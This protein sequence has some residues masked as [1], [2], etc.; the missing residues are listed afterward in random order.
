MIWREC[1]AH[2]EERKYRRYKKNKWGLKLAGEEGLSDSRTAG[3]VLICRIIMILI[4]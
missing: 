4:L 3:L 2:W 1:L